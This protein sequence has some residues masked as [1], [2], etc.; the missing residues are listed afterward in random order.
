LPP[1]R[2][3]R[4]CEYKTQHDKL[5]VENASI[6]SRGDFVTEIHLNSIRLMLE[7][8]ADFVSTVA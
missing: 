5:F 8:E 1:N 7:D 6:F 3:T 4:G 2:V